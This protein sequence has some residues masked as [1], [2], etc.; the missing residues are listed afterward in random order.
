MVRKG[1]G[2]GFYRVVGSEIHTTEDSASGMKNIQLHNLP[3]Q[4][5]MKLGYDY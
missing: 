3:A 1:S 5:K 4:S 2:C